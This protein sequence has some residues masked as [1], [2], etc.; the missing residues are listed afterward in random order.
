MQLPGGGRGSYYLCCRIKIIFTANCNIK[1]NIP[2]SH[3]LG[4][5][6][7]L[8]ADLLILQEN[9]KQTLGLT[10]APVPKF[11][12]DSGLNI[13]FNAGLSDLIKDSKQW[14]WT[15]WL[16]KQWA[17]LEKKVRRP[18]PIPHFLVLHHVL[19]LP[20]LETQIKH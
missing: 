15:P 8:D 13:S 14:Q 20:A 10:T 16:W 12:F 7:L 6:L 1:I 9:I 5:T 4:D 18:P 11:P 2:I 17:L 3:K 19:N